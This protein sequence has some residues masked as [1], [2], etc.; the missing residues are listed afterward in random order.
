MGPGWAPNLSVMV[1]NAYVYLLCVYEVIA[2]G[3]PVLTDLSRSPVRT[4]GGKLCM[5]SVLYEACALES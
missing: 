5:F 4:L 2:L 1:R 3:Y